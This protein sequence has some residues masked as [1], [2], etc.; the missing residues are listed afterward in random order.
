MA[1]GGLMESLWEGC[2]VD[3]LLSTL[4]KKK[5]KLGW[6]EVICSYNLFIIL[7]QYCIN[8]DKKYNYNIHCLSPSYTI[9]MSQC[10]VIYCHINVMRV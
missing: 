8:V 5:G 3:M 7:T 1:S 4:V 9:N 6:Y 10:R 2:Q